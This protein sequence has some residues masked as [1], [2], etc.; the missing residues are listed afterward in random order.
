M[1]LL[2]LIRYN[3]FPHVSMSS[4]LQLLNDFSVVFAVLLPS[5]LSD[6]YGHSS[7]G[8]G[9]ACIVKVKLAKIKDHEMILL[10]LSRVPTANAITANVRKDTS[11]VRGTDMEVEGMVSWT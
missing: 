7:H 8:I 9:T 11:T 6:G 4:C 10:F 2:I 3:P 1:K 5:V